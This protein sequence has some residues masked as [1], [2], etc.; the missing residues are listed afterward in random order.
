MNSLIGIL[1]FLKLM[2][3]R[4]QSVVLEETFDKDS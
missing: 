4:G 1:W 2:R 3:E